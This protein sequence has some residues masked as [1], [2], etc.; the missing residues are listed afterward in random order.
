MAVSLRSTTLGT[1]LVMVELVAI[2]SIDPGPA[3]PPPLVEYLAAML[4]VVIEIAA[5][6]AVLR[7]GQAR[8]RPVLVTTGLIYVTVALLGAVVTCAVAAF[9]PGVPGLSRTDRNFVGA[10]IHGAVNGLVILGLW[11]LTCALPELVRDAR[12]RERE[13]YEQQRAVD[14]LRIKAALEPHFLLNTLNT[15]A[16]LVGKQ[17]E[18]A[19]ELIGDLGDLL[20]DMVRTSDL[21]V[22]S[23]AAELAWLERYARLLEARHPGQLAVRLQLDDAARDVL[24]PVMVLQPIVENAI[25]HGALHGGGHVEVDVRIADGQ[26]RCTVDDDGPGLAATPVRAGARG[27]ELVRHRLAVEAPGSTLELASRA[28]GTRAVITLPAGPR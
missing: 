28:P 8:H 3:G 2:A 25:H 19:R 11:S 9:E 20:R 15:V 27:V 23:A 13:R 12:D 1:V 16:G 5:L 18:R 7:W 6:N 26:L 17:P 24:V 22:H 21:H 14:R 10:A 4:W